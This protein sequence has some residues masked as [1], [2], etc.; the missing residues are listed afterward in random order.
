MSGNY[1]ASTQF[2]FW[3]YDKEKLATHR[4]RL[5][6]ENADLVRRHPLP[7]QRE[8]SVFFNA[9]MSC[10]TT[11]ILSIRQLSIRWHAN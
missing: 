8:L 3:L 7:G 11:R 4:Q 1:W 2:R 9:R 6:D 5:E 10:P